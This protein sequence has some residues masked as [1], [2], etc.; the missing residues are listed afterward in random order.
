MGMTD[1]KTNLFDLERAQL[2]AW[3]VEH[4]EKPFRA[5]QVMKWLYH[6]RVRD[7]DL[8]TDLSKSTREMLKEKA[9]LVFPE[10]IVDKTSS[11]GTR[12][13]VFRYA[14]GNSIETVYIP[15]PE[16]G[17]LC[18]SSQAGC[19][20]ACPFCSTA[21]E[22]FNRNLTTGEIVVQIWLAKEMLGCERNGNKRL[23]TNVVLMG[24]GEPLVNFSNVI[25]ATS[26]M[27]DDYAF[28]LSKRRVTL[29]TSGIVPA[30]HDLR[31]V[32][33]VSLAIS[34]HAPNDELRNEIVPINERYGLAALLEAC[35]QYV[36][37]NNQ[38]GGITWEYVML[39]GVNDR[40]E[41]ADELAELLR[42]IPGKVNLIPF[43]P[44]RGSK[45]ECSSR[46]AMLAF[47][48]RLTEKG[49]TATIR[50]TR[51]EDI[52]AACGQ[53]VGKINDRSRRERVLSR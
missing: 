36:E 21:H 50:K 6:E 23:V 46:N 52:D 7:F 53:L 12:K 9:T 10:A 34:L 11:D 41:H 26:L 51:G 40:L 47:Q 31:K 39:K 15:E 27:M 44:F 42:G 25:P 19:A 35:K 38:H 4:G 28:G 45:Y 13:W 22:G 29:S 48:R 43:N 5:K 37:H 18:I 49:Y 32:T 3:F 20:L 17:T 30:I 33:D 14:C 2:E 1:K 16:R 24:M 8:M